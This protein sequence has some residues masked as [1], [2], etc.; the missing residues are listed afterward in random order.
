LAAARNSPLD[1]LSLII[2]FKE[3][4][5]FNKENPMR[6]G[7]EIVKSTNRMLLVLLF[8]A[9][10]T[11]AGQTDRDF[12]LFEGQN[13]VGN[14]AIRGGCI[15]SPDRG[16][17]TITGSGE[18]MWEGS[19]SFHFIWKRCAGDL[20]MECRVDWLGSGKNPHR[21]VGWMVRDGLE[22]DAVYADAVV[23]GDG[24]ISLQFRKTKGGVTEE[25]Q[26][27]VRAPAVLRLERNAGVFTLSVSSKA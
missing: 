7:F 3:Q 14:T 8:A 25:V 16:T 5:H 27:P 19:D 15:Y 20:L 22:P 10:W 24:L 9:S 26:S 11:A 21:K 4:V 1:F 18:N 13:E 17:Y 12:V 2:Y 6:I 23:H